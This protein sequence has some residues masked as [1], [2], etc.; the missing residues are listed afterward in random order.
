MDS[1]YCIVL[2]WLRIPRLQYSHAI[3]LLQVL[4]L[5]FVDGIMFGGIKINVTS[6][7]RRDAGTGG[8]SFLF[9][10]QIGSLT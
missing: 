5:C 1:L 10:V 7:N 4:S 3:V 9:Y 2:A 6:G 8:A